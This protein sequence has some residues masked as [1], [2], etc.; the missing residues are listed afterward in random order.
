MANYFKRYE[1]KSFVLLILISAFLLAKAILATAFGLPNA[2]K[3]LGSFGLLLTITG[4]IQLE[5]S[6]LFDK[7]IAHYVDD[8]KFPDGPPS[9]ITREIIDNPDAPILSW[10]RNI[11]FFNLRTGFWLIVVG[12]VAQILAVWL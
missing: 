11:C 4:V 5:I 9:Y 12:T 7:V 2:G 6:G 8:E 10:L 3:W 1:R